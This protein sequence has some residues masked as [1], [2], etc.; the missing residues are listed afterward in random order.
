MCAQFHP[1]EDLVVSASLDQ[2]IRI[3]DISGLRKKNVSPANTNDISRVR[4]VSGVSSVD[5]FGQ[6]DV[7][8]KHVL[9][10]HDRGVLDGFLH[11]LKKKVRIV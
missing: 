11:I 9:E 10:G 8:V 2:T 4:S 7:V 3:W 1:T 6:P 5:L